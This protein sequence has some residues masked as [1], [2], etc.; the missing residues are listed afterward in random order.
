MI[1]TSDN[2]PWLGMKENGGRALPLRDGKFSVYE[3]GFREPC[4]MRWPGRI[5]AGATC[6]ELA[7]TIDLLPTLAGLAGAALPEDHPIDGKDIWPLMSGDPH[8]TTPHEAFFYHVG[9][10]R[11]VRAGDWKLHLPQGKEPVRLYDL[12]KD[13]SEQHDLAPEHPETVARLTLLYQDYERRMKAG[14]RPPGQVSM[15]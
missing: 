4:V 2:G 3:G 9:A 14:F 13:L 5:P 12:R 1:Y 11:A 6:N 7:A 15:G 10:R 8:A